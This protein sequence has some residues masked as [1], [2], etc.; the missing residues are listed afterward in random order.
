MTIQKV[1]IC[2]YFAFTPSQLKLQGKKK[3]NTEETKIISR[4]K[5]TVNCTICSL[6]STGIDKTWYFK[7]CSI[8]KSKRKRKMLQSTEAQKGKVKADLVKRENLEIG[9]W[10]KWW[11]WIRDRVVKVPLEWKFPPSVGS[12]NSSLS[13]G[14]IR[15]GSG[16]RINGIRKLHWGWQSPGLIKIIILP[17]NRKHSR[18]R[19]GLP[20]KIF[21]LK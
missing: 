3:I 4:N 14:L 19:S 15:A 2:N 5:S 21:F 12:S 20:R 7:F 8:N 10:K 13:I 16:L 18:W 1:E 11:M 9:S 6:S 17:L